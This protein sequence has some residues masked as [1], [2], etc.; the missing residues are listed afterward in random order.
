MQSLQALIQHLERSPLGRSQV[1]LRHILA[2][3]S[4]CVGPAVAQHS[5]PK[6]LHQGVLQVAVSS[7]AWAQ[8]LT[9]ERLQILKKLRQHLP[10][11]I[12]V[13][14]LRFN[15]VRWQ[16]PRPASAGPSVHPLADHPSWVGTPLSLK[17]TEQD[18]AEAVFQH[19]AAGVRSQFADQATCP[20]CGLPCPR[21]E[22]NRW[23]VCAI[24]MTH[25]WRSPR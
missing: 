8:N 24:C 25:R 19:W 23:S 18:S 4:T 10:A 16:L 5:Q 20:E 9:F 7:A 15:T 21:Q 6:H 2:V 11:H 12:Q 13:Q 22:L 3:W 1:E 17:R 14:E